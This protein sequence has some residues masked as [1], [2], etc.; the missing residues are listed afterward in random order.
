[1]KIVSDV[2]CT[3]IID[4]VVE[5]SDLNFGDDDWNK[6]AQFFVENYESTYSGQA[7]PSKKHLISL[8]KKNGFLQRNIALLIE[9]LADTI[10]DEFNFAKDYEEDKKITEVQE[11]AKLRLVAS[12]DKQQK[13]DYA[14]WISTH[15]AK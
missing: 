7:L 2:L 4:V 11:A 14:L 13:E 8:I 3:D 6:I 5:D 1:M 15:N 10:R 12:F 9:T